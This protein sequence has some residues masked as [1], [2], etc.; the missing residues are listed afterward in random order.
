LLSFCRFSR[1]LAL[2]GVFG[3]LLML[4]SGAWAS[5]VRTD[6][7]T[8][9][10]VAEPGTLHPGKTLW[11]MLHLKLKDGWHTYWR[12][13][14][15]SGQP[16]AIAWTL[17]DGVTAGDI[18]WPYPEPLPYG[19]LLN[20]GYSHDAYHLVP[21]ALPS[22][23]PEGKPVDIS[24]KATWLVCSDICVPEGGS[25]TL[26]LPTADTTQQTD[27]KIAGL[28]RTARARLP[29]EPDWKVGLAGTGDK[30]VLTLSGAALDGASVKSA[31]F[32]PY[33]WGLIEPAAKQQL[34]TAA[35]GLSLTMTAGQ[36]PNKGKLDGVLVLTGASGNG[37]APR[38]YKI[39]ARAGVDAGVVPTPPASAPQAAA[40]LAGGTSPAANVG[41]LTA[42]LFAVLG[43]IILNLMPCVFPILSMK[44]IALIRHAEKDHRT[45]RLHG[46]AYAAGVLVCFAVLALILIALKAGGAATGWGFQLQSPVFVAA[47][48]YLFFL[49]GLNLSGVFE[50]GT[51]VMDVGGG[52]SARSG[53]G[54]DFFTGVL[55]AVVS[56]PCTAPFMGVAL[57]FALTQPTAVAL[58]VFLAL[59]VGFA[60]PYLLLTFVPALVR[61]LPKPGAWMERTRQF[62]AFPLYASVAWLVWVLAIQT[63][64]HGVF[65]AL[66]G[67][68]LLAFAVWL[69]KVTL[70]AKAH[71]R[72]A[73]RAGSTVAAAAALGLIVGLG[74][75]STP[76][77]PVST[78]GRSAEGPRYE[79]FSTERLAALRAAGKPVFVNMTAAWCITC[80]VNERVAL[81]S[82]EVSE[83]FA[84]LDIAYLKGDWTNGDPQITALLESFGRSGVPLYALYGPGNAKPVLLPQ[85]LTETIVLDAL[86][87]L[88]SQLKITAKTNGSAS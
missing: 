34:A 77:T 44:A 11:V 12:N 46:L 38:A 72:M 48:A 15:D 35:N 79:P 22:G 19:P 49:L 80:L 69:A 13:P 82:A 76:S 57:G 25:F 20:Y 58:A 67:I 64:P 26:S 17:P 37:P 70:D 61:L 30:V 32:F 8:A 66:G 83:R 36:T 24:A 4:G 50:I 3:V 85:L 51:S 31:T 65:A 71:G 52:L 84:S 21:I 68:V 42:M 27:A 81:S 10:I 9:Q 88:S 1:I 39:S 40:P 53:F 16:P 28:F 29:V 41:L 78:T 6:H 75:F 47:M 33:E 55:A 23:W 43:G 45:V 59:G 73:G 7:V 14:G 56:T 2:S 63:G 74:A 62:L 18:R 54:G 60:L 86:Q 87:D 5:I